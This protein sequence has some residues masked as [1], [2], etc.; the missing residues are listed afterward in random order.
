MKMRVIK[1]VDNFQRCLEAEDMSS[2]GQGQKQQGQS[3]GRG[4]EEPLL[5]FP[6][7]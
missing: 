2:R 7:V 1:E 3:G 5:R 6:E 4:S